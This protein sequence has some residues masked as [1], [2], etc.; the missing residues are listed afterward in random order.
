ME[1][2][3]K[4]LFLLKDEKVSTALLKLGVPT[5]VG[6][7]IAAFHS[8]DQQFVYWRNV[9]SFYITVYDTHS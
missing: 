7:L 1:N 8:F 6:M 9:Y 3:S 5:M 4:K 2:E